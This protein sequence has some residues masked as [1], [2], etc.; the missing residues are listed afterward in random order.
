MVDT[1]LNL[2]SN[3]FIFFLRL[4]NLV[5]HENDKEKCQNF[6]NLILSQGY[7]GRIM[8]CLIEEDVCDRSVFSWQSRLVA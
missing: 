8:D 1:C 7:I 4:A 5:L 3:G 6:A 2:S